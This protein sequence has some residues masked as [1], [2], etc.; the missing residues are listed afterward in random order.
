MTKEELAA[1]IRQKL[2]EAL[3]FITESTT[4]IAL[5][6]P[7]L[8]NRVANTEYYVIKGEYAAGTLCGQLELTISVMNGVARPSNLMMAFGDNSLTQVSI[9]SPMDMYESI[10]AKHQAYVESTMYGKSSAFKLNDALNELEN[11]PCPPE[12]HQKIAEIV[13]KLR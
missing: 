6:Q 12:V 11:I 3:T 10:K 7:T 5:E 8:Q 1:A 13:Q 9:T 4:D 2:V